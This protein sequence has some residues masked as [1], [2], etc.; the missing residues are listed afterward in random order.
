[1]KEDI[2]S[3]L[4]AIEEDYNTCF[5]LIRRIY[6]YLDQFGIKEFN[7]YSQYKWSLDRD[8]TKGYSYVCVRYGSSLKKKCM[9]RRR[10]DMENADLYKWVEHKDFIKEALDEAY[11]YVQEKVNAVKNKIEDLRTIVEDYEEKLDDISKDYDEKKATRKV[12][13]DEDFAQD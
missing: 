1:M 8:K 12:L 11:Q 3:T 4:R 5:R 9:I 2:E 13:R 10:S 6:E 7:R